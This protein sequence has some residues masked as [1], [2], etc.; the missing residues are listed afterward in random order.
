MW[1]FSKKPERRVAPQTGS[2]VF[3]AWMRDIHTIGEGVARLGG[4]HEQLTVLPPLAEDD[5]RAIEEEL[6]HPL[7]RSLRDI[8]IKASAGFNAQW[9]IN[10]KDILPPELTSAEW[11]LLEFAAR[12]VISLEDHRRGWVESVF[13]DPNNEHDAPWHHSM[14]FIHVANGDLIAFD[15]RSPS[16]DPPVI[17]L[18]H[19]GHYPGSGHGQRLGDNFTDFM[20]RWS[21]LGCVGPESWTWEPFYDQALAKLNPD[22]DSARAWRCV[23]L[24]EG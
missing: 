3:D 20:S 9:S 2:A 15:L 23:V 6:E 16:D 21:R 14:P 18:N 8:A 19:E 11:C 7:P 12:D 1:P 22:G 5:L 13:S 10:K 24:G 4:E 17:Y